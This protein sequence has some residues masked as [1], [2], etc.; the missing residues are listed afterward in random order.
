MKK[1]IVILGI[2]ITSN[3]I[4]K[5]QNNED[6]LQY[7]V[8]RVNNAVLDCPHFGGLFFKF[9]NENNWKTIENNHQKRYV[10]YGL[11]KNVG[12]NP[13]EK[14]T[15]YLEDIHFPKTMVKEIVNIPT[16]KEV[17]EYINNPQ[18]Y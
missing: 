17:D 14:Y 6:T 11:P 3:V 9:C 2:L 5:A 18:K 12:Y 15:K 10:I 1:S 7:V 13:V 16:K 8:M 4:M